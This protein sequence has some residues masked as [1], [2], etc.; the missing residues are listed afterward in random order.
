VARLALL[1]SLVLLATGC[2]SDG[3][4]EQGAS[5]K[6]ATSTSSTDDEPAGSSSPSQLSRNGRY[7]GYVRGAKSEPRVIVFD[8]AQAFSGE[9]ANRA[10]AEDG[11]VEP[12]EPVPNDHYERNPEQDV[13][14]LELAPG[15]SVT[16]AWPASFLMKYVSR[17][18]YRKCER[19]AAPMPCTQVPLSLDTFFA[20]T[21]R[22]LSADYGIP[23][24]LRI[25][26][27]LVESIDEQYFP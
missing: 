4:S 16:A 9:A 14:L 12:G 19:S 10:A 24:W 22:D 17:E 5:S 25:R 2:G 6:P 7:F 13:E 21:N 27:G 18:E 3:T 26:D 1:V 11:V 23:V 20:A 15:A 8:V